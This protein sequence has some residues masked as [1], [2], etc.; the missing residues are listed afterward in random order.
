MTNI[1]V[2][3]ADDHGIVRAGIRSIIQKMDGIDVVGEAVNGS[4]ALELAEKIQPDVFLMDISMPVMNGLEVTVRVTK[5]FPKVRVIIFSMHTSEEYV[6]QA[7]RSGA[8][9]Y[10]LK[11]AEANEIE[12]AIRAVADGATY[13][14]PS[15]SQHVIEAYMHR[16]GSDVVVTDVLTSRQREILQLI[17]EGKALKVIANKLGLS[18][19]T[20]ET[21]R[22]RLMERLQIFEVA[23][24]VRY[25]IRNGIISS[26]Q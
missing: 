1:R 15:V 23:G 22:M 6:L 12:F 13:L 14:T 16:L 2:V 21:H 20:V 5:A 10:L 9:G 25:A 19:K 17:A 7:L 11:D 18:V 26:E 24:L 8:M 3:I 4:E